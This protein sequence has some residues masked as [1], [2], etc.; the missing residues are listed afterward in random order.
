MQII[1]DQAISDYMCVHQSIYVCLCV[2]MINANVYV[3]GYV[4]ECKWVSVYCNAFCVYVY[5]IM[6]TLSVCVCVCVCT[7]L[8]KRVWIYEN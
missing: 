3:S 2:C 1:S 8:I 4:C 7:M 5:A 6:Q